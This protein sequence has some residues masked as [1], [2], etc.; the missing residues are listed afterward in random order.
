MRLIYGAD[1]R[2]T[3]GN[4][5]ASSSMDARESSAISFVRSRSPLQQDLCWSLMEGNVS[6]QSNTTLA[7]RSATTL[8][9]AAPDRLAGP[10]N[11]TPNKPFDRSAG[12]LSQLD[13]LIRWLNLIAAPGRCR[14]WARL[15]FIHE[16]H[17]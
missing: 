17:G 13:N 9:P 5:L 2:I 7:I 14:R 4:M 6:L 11:G 8:R 12:R 10:F 16:Q 3:N 15:R 1:C